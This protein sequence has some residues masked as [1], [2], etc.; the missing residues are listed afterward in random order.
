MTN[1]TY[2]TDSDVQDA[3]Y[4]QLREMVKELKELTAD[5]GMY[6]N[7]WTLPLITKGGTVHTAVREPYFTRFMQD[8]ITMSKW[9]SD[10]VD[11]KVYDVGMDLLER[12]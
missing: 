10:A 8:N 4:E 6:I 3:Y 7:N 11:G 5:F 9:L 12:Q 2:K 1:K